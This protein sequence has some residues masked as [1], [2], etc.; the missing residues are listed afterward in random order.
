MLSILITACA[1]QTRQASVGSKTSSALVKADEVIGD[2]LPAWTDK[3]GIADGRLYVVGYSEMSADKSP[4]YIKKAA[5]MDGEVRLLSDAPS[6]FRV[7]TQNALRGQ[8][9]NR[10]SSFRYRQRFKKCLPQKA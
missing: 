7:L 1:S 4:H 5:L 3:S 9:L 6:D 8:A 10:L 2:K